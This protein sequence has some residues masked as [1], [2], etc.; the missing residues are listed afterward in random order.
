MPGTEPGSR[1]VAGKSTAP[2]GWL[3]SVVGGAD[4]HNEKDLV[5]LQK[6]S[7]LFLQH[8]L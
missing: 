4:A 2:E 6:R 8:F 1:D 3:P 5:W 7:S